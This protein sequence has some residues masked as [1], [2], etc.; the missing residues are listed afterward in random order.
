MLRKFVKMPRFIKRSSNHNGSEELENL[1][2]MLGKKA[3]TE[4][5]GLVK[6]TDSLMCTEAIHIAIDNQ[7]SA[8]ALINKTLRQKELLN[9]EIAVTLLD[10]QMEQTKEI[11]QIIAHSS[12]ATEICVSTWNLLF[13][14]KQQVKQR[15]AVVTSL[16]LPAATSVH[17][18]VAGSSEKK[19]LPEANMKDRTPAPIPQ[20]IISSTLLYQ[21]HHSLFPAEK[22]LVG[23]GRRTGS[24]IKIDAVFEVTGE[25]SS[26]H[27]WADA[28]KLARALISMSETDSYFALWI[29][30]HP[31]H[32]AEMTYPSG[33]DLKQETDWLRDYSSNLVNAIMVKDRFIRFWG[34][35]LERKQIT[36]SIA[37]SGVKRA[38]ENDYLYQL[39][40]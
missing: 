39:E 10:E 27:V 16:T 6:N 18:A 5:A 9:P 34:K 38:A 22:M 21:M 11:F 36:V 33:T 13:N 25:S 2:I 23:A 17:T 7:T 3:K 28:G 35:A 37:G 4:L 1:S 31:G 29:H 15:Y 20:L 32:G 12:Q 14:A 24:A 30:S 40:S 8:R 26:G 19:L